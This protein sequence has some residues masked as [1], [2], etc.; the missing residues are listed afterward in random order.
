MF[1]FNFLVFVG[2]RP[3]WGGVGWYE[4]AGTERMVI[5]H[6]WFRLT[7]FLERSRASQI[8]YSLYYAA[9]S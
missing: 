5:P 1:F 2:V 8:V 4:I 3:R 6:L 9:M 7:L